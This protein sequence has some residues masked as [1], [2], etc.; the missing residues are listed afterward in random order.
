LERAS[1]A[2]GES[3]KYFEG[4]RISPPP[5]L[6]S[7]I[8]AERIIYLGSP[9]VP[10]VSE[11]IIAQL[12]F[13]EYESGEKP[14]IMYINSTG[15]DNSRGQAVSFETES[16]AILD[17]MS[18]I[19]PPVHTICIGQAVGTAAMLLASGK[20]GNRFALPNCTILLK[21]T[22][23]GNAALPSVR[24]RHWSQGATRDAQHGRISSF[25]ENGS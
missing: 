11:L 12:L 8:L 19:R 17:V 18:Y 22:L 4:A 16:L 10:K 9:L 1:G 23:R 6:P 14:I 7:L 21:T 25:S 2:A 15:N 24:H 3:W 5:D 20:A 13:L